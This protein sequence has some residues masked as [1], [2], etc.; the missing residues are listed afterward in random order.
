MICSTNKQAR[1]I[2]VVNYNAKKAEVLI[3]NCTSRNKRDLAAEFDA[4]ASGN[5]AVLK[6]ARHTSLSFAGEED[7]S[8]DKMRQIVLYFQNA[9]AGN[10]RWSQFCAWRHHDTAHP[11][12]HIVSNRVTPALTVVDDSFDHYKF[13]LICRRIE[14]HFDLKRCPSSWEIPAGLR[15]RHLSI[16]ERKTGVL[17]TGTRI[18]QAVDSVLE[19]NAGQ[20]TFQ[21]FSE[22]LEFQG[23]QVSLHQHSM[24]CPYLLYEM[25]GKIM[26]GYAVSIACSI[27]GLLDRNVNLP[28]NREW[29]ERLTD[30]SYAANDPDN[31]NLMRYEA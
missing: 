25:G 8:D 9:Q 15:R 24:G 22:L 16:Q 1:F 17:T 26:R 11:H 3:T 21:Q 12:V 20:L 28:L 23:V 30:K 6:P 7:I 5:P 4:V 13:Q 29:L 14:K 10:S 2:D 19:F 27:A 31:T 18:A